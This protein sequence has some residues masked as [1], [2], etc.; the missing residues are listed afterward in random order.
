MVL[1][2]VSTLMTPESQRHYWIFAGYLPS[3]GPDGAD[4]MTMRTFQYYAC[5]KVPAPHN[6]PFPVAGCSLTLQATEKQ[7][8]KQDINPGYRLYIISKSI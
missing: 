3:S 2:V 8:N 7:D 5:E 4:G 1:F 6:D